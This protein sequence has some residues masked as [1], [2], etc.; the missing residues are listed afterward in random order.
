MQKDSNTMEEGK[1]EK[2]VQIILSQKENS[3]DVE[4]VKLDNIV[5]SK[6]NKRP[7][8]ANVEKALSLLSN[9]KCTIFVLQLCSERC[10]N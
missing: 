6:E 5:E 8:N 2:S 3:K 7:L 9:P 1:S 4:G 10:L